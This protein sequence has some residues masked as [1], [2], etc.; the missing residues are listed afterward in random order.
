MNL[1]VNLYDTLVNDRLLVRVYDLDNEGR[2]GKVK[3]FVSDHHPPLEVNIDHLS[4]S[5]I[6]IFIDGTPI[7]GNIHEV[8]AK[9]YAGDKA[10]LHDTDTRMIKLGK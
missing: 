2:K 6:D 5:P 9:I 1:R 10:L 8:T 3:I 4:L 7:T